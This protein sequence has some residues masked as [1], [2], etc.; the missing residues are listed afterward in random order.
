MAVE[1]EGIEVRPTW[2]LTR[3]HFENHPLTPCV[4]C[5]K[6]C[7]NKKTSWDYLVGII[8]RSFFITTPLSMPNQRFSFGQ[9]WQDTLYCAI[10]FDSTLQCTRLRHASNFWAWVPLNIL[11]AIGIL[12]TSALLC[13]EFCHSY[14]NLLESPY[15]ISSF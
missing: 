1:Q 15:P 3:Y 4:D 7:I 11:P 8:H 9:H 6:I 10:N 13:W 12:S 14:L 2:P 5:K